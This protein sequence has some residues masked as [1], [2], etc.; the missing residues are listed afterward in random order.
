MRLRRKRGTT[1]WLVT[2]EHQGEHARPPR[3]IAAIFNQRWS[4]KRVH[5]AIEWLYANEALS[6]F[7]RVAYAAKRFNPYPAEFITV[8]A[9]RWSW[10]IICGDNPFLYARIV[11]RFTCVS[12][13]ESTATWNERSISDNVREDS[14][15]RAMST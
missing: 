2:W 10:R 15:R 14:E 4:D 3:S 12:D 13:E 11:D 9:V 7:E 1:V 5:E 6:L 8:G